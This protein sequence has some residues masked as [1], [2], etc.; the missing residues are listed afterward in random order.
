MACGEAGVSRPTL[1]RGGHPLPVSVCCVADE[2]ARL[3]A[4]IE[5]QLIA[6]GRHR[7]ALQCE[8]PVTHNVLEPA[9]QRSRLRSIG[10]YRALCGQAA[11]N[12]VLC[13]GVAHFNGKGT[14]SDADKGLDTCSSR[15]ATVRQE[16]WQHTAGLA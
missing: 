2:Q 1:H 7:E 4:T 8:G 3:V 12:P 6:D 11:K 16:I 10:A 5:N 9:L 14:A 13:P 15:R